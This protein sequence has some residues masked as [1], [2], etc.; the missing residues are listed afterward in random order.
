MDRRLFCFGSNQALRI[1]DELTGEKMLSPTTASPG[2]QV[3]LFDFDHIPATPLNITG[4][5][6]ITGEREHTD[7][8]NFPGNREY[9]NFLNFPGL[10]CTNITE[11][12]CII[13]VRAEQ[14]KLPT[15]PDCACTIKEL[16][17]HSTFQ[18]E[19]VL[20]LPHGRK[21]VVVNIKRQRWM[22][23]SCGTTVTQPLDVMTE[24]RYRMTRRLEEY[25]GEQALLGTE[26]S[27]AEETGVSP[28]TIR[29]IRLK[30]VEQLKREIQLTTPRVLG[31]DGVRADE[32]R[33]RVIFTNIES[34]E[35]L[36]LIKSGNSKSI[37][38]RIRAFP[39]Y[40]RITVV[41]IDMCV[42]LRAAVRKALGDNVAIVID[43]FHIAR[44][45]NQ[46]MD[47]VRNRLFPRVKKKREP[48][49][50]DRPRPEPFRKR[51]ADLT[52]NVKDGT[53][54]ETYM[55]FWYDQK[56]ELK[57]AYDL[58]EG[59]M[60]MFDAASYGRKGLMSAVKAKKFYEQ[61][62]EALP[63]DEQYKDL[64]EDFKPILSAMKNWGEFIF[65]R[66]DHNFTNAYTESMN[67]KV[68]DILRES[69][70]CL[71]ET[72]HAKIV[73]GTRLR[74]EKKE[75]RQAEMMAVRPR[76]KRGPRGGANSR[77]VTARTDW[78]ALSGRYTLPD[79]SQ[80]ALDFTN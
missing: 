21:S 55:K 1:C 12:T 80:R 18:M 57:M 64:L 34:G 74:K 14:I 60:E 39:G 52:K 27:L 78:D 47:K 3:G 38:E 33:R 5:R 11:L 23:K 42:T 58:K 25:C 16:K 13:K 62:Q 75:A 35:V 30:K 20:D 36:D 79:L 73:F 31:L 63:V 28:R 9:V 72:L 10:R 22:C 61:W 4:A 69:R 66:F 44:T 29:S 17:A 15:Y 6:E 49:V 67:R 8:P 70:G 65:N 71:F 77:A 45:A 19:N 24:G 46:S 40:E 59:Y 50:P 7:L 37:A 54:D 56:P 32:H 41:T 2:F 68:K 53:D 26:L 51:R 76:V 48:G 43:V